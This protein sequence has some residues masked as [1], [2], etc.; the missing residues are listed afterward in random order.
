MLR[1]YR[2][3]EQDYSLKIPQGFG[4]E[5]S[6]PEQDARRELLEETGLEPA[7]LKPLVCFGSLYKTY[8]FLWCPVSLPT[9]RHD[10]QE[11]TEA[12]TGYE[13]LPLEGISLTMLDALGIHDP[14]TISALMIGLSL[15]NNNLLIE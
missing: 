11:L 7:S 12:I 4:I 9:L 2:Y 15:S 8:L 3:A 13:L 1:N 5:G 14:I 10:G 6:T